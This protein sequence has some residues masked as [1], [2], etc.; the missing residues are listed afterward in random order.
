MLQLIAGSCCASAGKLPF[1]R[2]TER[3]RER[4]MEVESDCL[5]CANTMCEIYEAYKVIEHQLAPV[6]AR[7]LLFI[8]DCA[9]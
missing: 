9:H 5:M 6:K 4:E 1:S 3:G 7:L 8:I 2:G